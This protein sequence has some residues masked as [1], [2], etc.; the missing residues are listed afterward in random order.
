MTMRTASEWLTPVKAS[1]MAA[2][3]IAAVACASAAV[4]TA[5]KRIVRL[6]GVLCAL[7]TML[8]LDIAF[9]WRWKLYDWLRSEAVSFRWY[10][11]RS[12]PQI[13]ALVAIGV[14]VL[15]AATSL[16]R[17]FAF[18][19]GAPLA[20]C[21]GLLSIGCWLTEVVSLHASDAVLYRHVGPL[22]SVSFLWMLAC[23]MTAAGIL[24]AGIRS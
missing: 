12:E 24:I 6:A 18:A 20:I 4:R 10:D 16:G 22:L 21:G 19:R 1:G 2:Y 14:A 11:Q 15:A 5:D 17:R 9:D 13:A 23:A 7:Y 3:L 8:L